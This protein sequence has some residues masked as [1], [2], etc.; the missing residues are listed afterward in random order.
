MW[1]P[2]DG[3]LFEVS[4]ESLPPPV[5]FT[6]KSTWRPSEL[7]ALE[8]HALGEL[9]LQH[10]FSGDEY[11][12]MPVLDKSCRARASAEKDCPAEYPS[13]ELRTSRDLP[14]LWRGVVALPH[15]KHIPL[16]GDYTRDAFPS[17][18]K[19]VDTQQFVFTPVLF[20]DV[21]A[22]DIDVFR[23]SDAPSGKNM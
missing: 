2:A 1:L 16:R 19:L 9:A 12:W 14:P 20:A 13:A 10:G 8:I 3:S 6:P 23:L 17:V 18:G 15:V 7:L 11:T 22:T 21:T 5:K 4:G